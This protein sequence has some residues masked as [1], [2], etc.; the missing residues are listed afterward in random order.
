MGTPV[1][2]PGPGLK[3]PQ[4]RLGTLF[5]AVGAVGV[6]I[7][8]MRAVGPLGASVLVLF[9][10]AVM[11]HVAGNALGCQLRANADA[12][13]RKAAA[14][15]ALPHVA[16]NGIRGRIRY[17]PATRLRDRTALGRT[18]PII[19]LIGA[20]AGGLGGGWLLATV[21][22]QH[23]TLGNITLGALSFGVLGGLWGFWASSFLEVFFDALVAAHRE[24]GKPGAVGGMTG[25]LQASG[26]GLGDTHRH[27]RPLR[28][29]G[30]ASDGPR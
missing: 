19:T 8:A 12:L 29:H 4:F 15:Q 14:N 1:D 25:T 9:S 10:L 27:R 13:R 2:H 24:T 30:L 17:A 5:W 22:W 23:A 21:N 3:P 6:L 26:D 11:A 20:V 18:M 16:H 7:T 28:G